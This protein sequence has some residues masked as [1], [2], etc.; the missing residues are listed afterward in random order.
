MSD[1]AHVW[2]AQVIRMEESQRLDPLLYTPLQLG[3]QKCKEEEEFP[4]SV[5]NIS[6][7][8]LACKCM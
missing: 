5:D 6:I 3:G 8:Q 2:I 4:A 1:L 7:M